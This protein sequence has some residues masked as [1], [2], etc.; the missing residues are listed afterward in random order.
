MI[1]APLELAGATHDTAT[2]PTLS[3]SAV[4]PVGAFGGVRG[5]AGLEGAEYSPLPIE[6]RA[7]TLNV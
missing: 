6:F 7:A 1:A 4:T 2:P 5:V 3:T